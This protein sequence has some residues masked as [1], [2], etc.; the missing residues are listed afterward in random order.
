MPAT[1]E[2]LIDLL[3]DKDFR[4]HFADY[5]IYELVAA[6]IKQLREKHQWTQAEL[7]LRAGM[8]QV[9]VS[10]VEN[11]DYTGSRISTLSK[12]ADAFD[13]ALIVR[14]APFSELIDWVAKLSPASFAPP[15]F[16]EELQSVVPRMALPRDNSTEAHIPSKI[17]ASQE[18]LSAVAAED[19][20]ADKPATKDTTA[21]A[22]A[23]VTPTERIPEY[24]IA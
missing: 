13:V 1:K 20:P 6:Q 5:Q 19:V 18:L 24:A 4:G 9:Q 23:P 7:G 3:R 16:D 11:P 10:R 21:T 22:L 12:L 2:Q 17:V 8:Q 14:L 15:S